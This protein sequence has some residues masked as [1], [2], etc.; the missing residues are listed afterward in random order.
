MPVLCAMLA[1][2]ARLQSFLKQLHKYYQSLKSTLRGQ[3][4]N[5]SNGKVAQM[6]Q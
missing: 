5:I 3:I 6:W 4:Y 1:A 2:I